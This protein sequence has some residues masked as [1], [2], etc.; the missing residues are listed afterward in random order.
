MSDAAI[1]CARC[2]AAGQKVGS[3]C[4]SCG[5]WLPDPAG[6]GIGPAGRLRGLSP[7]RRRRRIHTLQL[8]TALAAA[9]SALI[10]LAVHF[11]AHPDLLVITV[12][13]C[14]LVVAW[15]GVA[16]L[17]GRGVQGRR[18]QESAGGGPALPAA[19]AGAVP[20]LNAADTGDMVSRTSVTENTTALLDPVPAK[21]AKS[22]G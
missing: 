5:E 13:L 14:L 19:Q 11:G 18:G 8:L 9:V 20:A 6:A 21:K 10:T 3:Y 2:G 1:F 17:L 16:F 22:E 4:R 7:E 15:Q 12:L